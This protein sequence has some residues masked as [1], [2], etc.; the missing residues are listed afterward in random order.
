MFDRI[1]KMNVFLKSRDYLKLIRPHHSIKSLVVYAPVFFNFDFNYEAYLA[2]FTAFILF[3]LMSS[4][5]YIFNDL[6]DV[7]KD[8]K[9]ATK[10]Y[11]PIAIGSIS[12]NQAILFMIVLL[13]TT[14]I[15]SL[16]F[17]KK[18]LPILIFYLIINIFYTYVLKEVFLLDILTIAFGFVLRLLAG[19]A[20]VNISLSYWIIIITFL[21]AS[22]LAISKRM[23]GV[24]DVNQLSS[25]ISNL[26]TEKSVKFLIL[27]LVVFLIGSYISFSMFSEIITKHNIPYLPLNSVF[28]VAGLVKYV[29]IIFNNPSSYDPIE[30]FFK[31]NLLKLIFI[32]WILSFYII[33]SL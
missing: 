21:L 15:L 22:L 6:I 9:H 24:N 23:D 29:Q 11:R 14:I 26:Y 31:D 28:V 7:D 20:V 16:L 30:I 13:I 32:F 25:S 3:Y 27:M 17:S 33:K 1:S 5:I 18:I 4:T 12:K 8:K 19:A 2:T 10:R